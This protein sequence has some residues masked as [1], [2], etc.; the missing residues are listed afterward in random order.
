MFPLPIGVC[1]E[2]D[3]NCEDSADRC[4]IVDLWMFLFTASLKVICC[5][6]PDMAIAMAYSTHEMYVRL[7]GELRI[8]CCSSV[9]VSY[10]F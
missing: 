9:P 7:Q 5:S 3:V 4:W 8:P 2:E 1:F 10:V 6:I